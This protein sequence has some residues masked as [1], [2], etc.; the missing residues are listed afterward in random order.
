M[1]QQLHPWA[2]CFLGNV[3]QVSRKACR[4]TSWVV[5]LACLAG[6]GVAPALAQTYELAPPPPGGAIPVPSSGA[7][8]PS[9]AG[10]PVGIGNQNFSG[11]QY[12]VFVNGGSDLLLEQVR[13]IEP[14]AFRTNHQGQTVIQA[15][16]FNSPQNANNRLNELSMQGMGATI[17]EVP[18]AFSYSAQT[19]IQSPEIYAASGALPPIPTGA[20]PQIPPVTSTGPST[21]PLPP[22]T[23]TMPSAGAMPA[24]PGQGT[25][26]FGQE[27][28][29]NVIPSPSAYPVNTTPPGVSAAIPPGSA[30][31]VA[32]YYVVIPTAENN[33]PELSTEI[34]QLGTPVDR[35]Q[36]RLT[37]RGPH[38]AVGPFEDRDLASQ[39]SRFYRDAGIPNSRVYY[40]P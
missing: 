19:P 32:P 8:P 13:F 39:W 21:S 36:Q 29:Y 40:D 5:A 24:V 17:A 26:E 38:V 15:G 27:L 16:R 30:R 11:Q 1:K 2:H 20:V 18:V 6:V 35:V 34:I 25:V 33:L 12:V 3:P 22:I 28:A 10:S 31:I 23:S 4:R 14:T 7:M 37:P 9:S